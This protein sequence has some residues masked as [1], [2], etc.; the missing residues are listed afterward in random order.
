MIIINTLSRLVRLVQGFR[1]NHLPR[2]NLV[3]T[4]QKRGEVGTPRLSRPGLHLPRPG[5]A[6]FDLVLDFLAVA[7]VIG[8]LIALV[9]ALQIYASLADDDEEAE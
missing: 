6:M 2:A 1:I 4:C 3:P 5:P 9:A 8:G 7:A